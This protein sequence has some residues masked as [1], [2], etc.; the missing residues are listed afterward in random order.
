[1]SRGAPA[2]NDFAAEASPTTG[3]HFGKYEILR[4]IATGGMAEIHL[5]RARGVEG[6]E[7]LVVLKRILPQFAHDE[8]FVRMFLDEARLAAH[9]HHSNIVQVYDIGAVD[10]QYFLA[11]EY[12]NGAD[13]RQI[14]RAAV[15]RNERIPLEH[16]LTIMVAVLSGLHHAHTRVV[17]GRPLN[18]VH[19]DVSPQNVFVTFE[20]GVKLLDFGIA[21]ASDRLSETRT[22]TLKGKTSYMSPEQV[23]G[24]PLDRRSDV[25]AAAIMLWE[26]TTSRRLFTGDSELEI[27]R[28]IREEDSPR[29]SLH[30]F[31]YPLA[32]ERIVLK[33]LRRNWESRYQSAEEMQLELEA[34]ARQQKIAL[35]PIA[36]TRYMRELFGDSRRTQSDPV[37]VE[38]SASAPSPPVVRSDPALAAPPG[39][40]T[41]RSWIAVAAGIAIGSLVTWL[42][43]RPQAPELPPAPTPVAATP[44]PPRP[45][46]AKPEP[47]AVAKPPAPVP[48]PAVETPS[49]EEPA[50]PAEP[51]EPKPTAAAEEPAPSA[52]TPAPAVAHPTP[53][54]DAAPPHPAKRPPRPTVKKTPKPASGWDPDSMLPP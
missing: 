26:L 27:L 35:S 9:L 21:R 13:T 51:A 1:M 53:K 39:R 18:L 33:G 23:Q 24:M 11:M 54:R 14:M 38:T 5:A 42:L 34:F 46:P 29:P 6:F 12:L 2:K 7:K 44:E 36:L 15:R 3:E 8:E 17:D 48:A 25:F 4:K 16:A 10:Q 50:E 19:R 22:G 31:A 43:I 40:S 49:A 28:K 37:Q 47:A 20:G 45:E 32:L 52:P 30:S 41:A